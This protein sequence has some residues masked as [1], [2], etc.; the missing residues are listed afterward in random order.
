MSQRE[1]EM[2]LY[3]RTL[4]SRV[5]NQRRS[6]DY[7]QKRLADRVDDIAE[8]IAESLPFKQFSDDGHRVAVSREVAQAVVRKLGAWP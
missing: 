8:A 2:D 3:I 5:D 1:Q 7:L 4:E 6:L